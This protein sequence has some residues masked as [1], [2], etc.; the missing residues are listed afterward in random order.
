MIHTDQE[1]EG[2]ETT[3]LVKEPNYLISMS[4]KKV[5]IKI[6][7]LQNTTRIM[8]INLQSKWN[9]NI[10]HLEE[11]IE[12]IDPDIICFQDTRIKIDTK[13]HQKQLPRTLRVHFMNVE[14]RASSMAIAQKEE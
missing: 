11:I 2:E 6:P 14:E 12:L 10:K 4:E 1:A 9:D 3:M 8:S 5:K 13:Q 7:K